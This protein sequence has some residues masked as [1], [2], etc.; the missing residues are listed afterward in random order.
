MI[1]ERPQEAF[2][3]VT[4]PGMV[5]PVTAGR[6]VLERDRQ[7]TLRGRF[8]Y[9]RSYLARPDAVEL[10]PVELRLTPGTFETYGLGGLFGTLRDAGPD[11]WGRRLIER[12]AG[13][14][15][16]SELDY[17]LESPDDRAGAVG[18]GRGAVPPAPLRRFNRTLDLTHLA[19]LADRL[20]R[21]LPSP[22]D[23]AAGLVEDLMLIGTSMG[24]ARPKT[25]VEDESGLWLAKFNRHDDRWNIARVEHGLLTLA[26]L[27]GLR[28]AE[29]R[30]EAIAGGDVLL[31]RRF[32]RDRTAEGYARARMVSALTILRAD[33]T[34]QRDRW[35]YVALAEELRRFVERPREDAHELF[36]RMVFNALVS[37]L[38]DHPRNHAFIAPNR[39]W[40]LSP[41]YD[42]TP[43]LVTAL[44][45][46]DLAM[47][48]GRFGRMANAANL[49][50]EAGRFL[51]APEE[52]TRI[53]DEME[54]QIG[55]LW[56]D[57]LRAAGVTAADI[58]RIAS[59]FL[60]PGFR[61]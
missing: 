52:A 17:L 20:V 50:S 57:T 5:A 4:L 43:S 19:A 29:S 48:A 7:G 37:N 61:Q 14:S 32:D 58:E 10:D 6:F 18:F 16:P 45:R 3:Y 39:A 30:V 8:V 47:T 56:Y 33:E 27:V 53:I 42:L 31:V 25:V 40:K 1:S 46:R 11:Y 41:A 21:D 28:S 60:Y 15:V 24:G 54:S 36:R 26:R 23:S 55:R 9:G 38:D 59:A 44:D 49:A 2:V 12:R 34:L 35:S 51:L 22:G 13:L